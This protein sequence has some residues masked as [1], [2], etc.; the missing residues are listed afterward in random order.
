MAWKD[1]KVVLFASNCDG[2]APEHK[3]QRWCSEKKNHTLVRQPN[4]IHNYN[5]SMGGVDRA[6]QNI[7][8]YR[9]AV[10]SKKWWRPLFV[11]VPDM[12]MQNAWI[13]YRH[14]KLPSDPNYDLMNFRDEVVFVYLAK[15]AE[16]C[17]AQS[18]AI[19]SVL[20]D[21]RFD[22]LGHFLETC[23]TTKRCGLCGKN[24]RKWCVKCKKGVHVRCF[25]GYHGLLQA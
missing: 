2:R 13:L 20:G 16:N 15:Y 19:C 9:I 11:W 6:D 14:E 7:A 1:R 21:V 18:N 12:A 22:M 24:I 10:Q 23:P 8:A 3:V 25:N 4:A 5:A 17:V